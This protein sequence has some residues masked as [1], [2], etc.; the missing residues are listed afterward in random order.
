MARECTIPFRPIGALD[1][2]E[3]GRHPSGLF[4]TGIELSYLFSRIKEEP[5]DSRPVG[6]N[7]DE[8]PRRLL[9]QRVCVRTGRLATKA[10]THVT[11]M[12]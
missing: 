7:N 2:D 9:V 4:C 6:V 12:P 1:R 5:C 11:I 3:A 10:L 8:V